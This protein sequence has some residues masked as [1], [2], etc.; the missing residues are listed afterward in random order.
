MSE[1]SGNPVP[2]RARR[3]R[4]AAEVTDAIHRVTLSELRDH[5]FDAVTFDRVARLAQMSKATVYRRYRSPAHL[6]AETLAAHA[7]HL[8]LEPTGSLRGD[9]LQIMELAVDTIDSF[10]IDVYRRLIGYRDESIEALLRE[11]G[12]GA[13]YSLIGDAVGEAQRRGE[14]G[15]LGVPEKTR[16]VPVEVLHSR[17]LLT[18]RQDAMA[19][20]IV[21]HVALPLFRA[22]SGQ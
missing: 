13:A 12:A 11:S 22:V 19:A 9:L 7:S 21:D 10:G 17:I 20:D 3:R 16:H 15:P 14:I 1:T 4:S 8:T 5:G 6:I 2:G 18:G